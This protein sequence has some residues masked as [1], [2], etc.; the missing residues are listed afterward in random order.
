MLSHDEF[1]KSGLAGG[2]GCLTAVKATAL[3]TYCLFINSGDCT[4][5][6][7]VN[8]IIVYFF[9]LNSIY[10]WIKTKWNIDYDYGKIRIILISRCVK[11]VHRQKSSSS[12]S[13]DCGSS[14][15]IS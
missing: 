14:I 11:G 12:S 9:C 3:A 2:A 10:N 1:A 6:S 15:L 13:T 4:E 7:N 5:I 8:L